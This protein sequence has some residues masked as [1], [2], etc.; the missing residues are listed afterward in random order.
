MTDGAPAK[1]L[2]FSSFFADAGEAPTD[3]AFAAQS[4][5][6][7]SPLGRSSITFSKTFTDRAVASSDASS[8]VKSSPIEQK[9]SSSAHRS[10]PQRTNG[11]HS[12]PGAHSKQNFKC[13]S[14]P[15]LDKKLPKGS[16]AV[17]RYNGENVRLFSTNLGAATNTKLGPAL[18]SVGSSQ[19]SQLYG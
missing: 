9:H 2:G 14:D 17:L 13:I 8:R 15:E 10:T 19:W 6:R 7:Q 16:K 1:K 11:K 5:S 18:R 3:L 12:R 4:P